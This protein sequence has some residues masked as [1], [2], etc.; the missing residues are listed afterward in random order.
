MRILA[1]G[2]HPDDLEILCAGTLARYAAEGH[3]VSMAHVCSG[4][5]GHYRMPPEELVPIRR[6][7]AAAAAAVIGAETL[8]LDLPDAG[9][10]GDA[11]EQR[12]AM[13]DLIR[14]ARPDVILTHAPGDYMPDHVAVSQL[15]FDASFAATLPHLATT[16]PCHPKVAP[17]Y[18]FDTLAGTGFEPEEYVDVTP[19]MDV[20]R[21]MLAQH[22][23]QLTWLKEHDGIDVM[24]FMEALARVRGIQ[25]G[26]RF[27]EGFRRV[28][29]WPRMTPSRLLP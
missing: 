16:H 8:T 5:L 27:A 13:V 17:L 25:C 3:T 10:F 9:A 2:A 21:R 22:Q 26:V 29:T 12:R 23:S 14:Q 11:P 18:H 24:E 15:V 19:V 28:R 7:E 1:V 6:G 20:K 4:H